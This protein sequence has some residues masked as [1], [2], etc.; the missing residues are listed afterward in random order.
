MKYAKFI[1]YMIE[2]VLL[3]IVGISV[4]G[5]FIVG[6]LSLLLFLQ[7]ILNSA[8]LGIIAT[9]IIGILFGVPA[10]IFIYDLKDKEKKE[11]VKKNE[12]NKILH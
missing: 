5:L 12:K 9:L 10:L 3:T 1:K 6:S 8:Q 2:G 7:P 4:V 11:R